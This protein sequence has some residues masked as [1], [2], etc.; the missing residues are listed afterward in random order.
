MGSL[1]FRIYSQAMT[2]MLDMDLP[3]QRHAGWNSLRLDIPGLGNGLYYVKAGN[4]P[5]AKVMVL[6]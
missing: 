6:Q 5:A 3:G 1:K 4:A 2:A